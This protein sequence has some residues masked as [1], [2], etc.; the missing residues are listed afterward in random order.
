V[1]RL[2]CAAGLAGVAVLAGLALGA[3][4]ATPAA[5][6]DQPPT[7]TGN[8][9]TGTYSSST[10][11]PILYGGYRLPASLTPHVASALCSGGGIAM[12]GSG[13]DNSTEC[14]VP[15]LTSV[16]ITITFDQ[17]VAQAC[18]CTTFTVSGYW[19]Y[20]GNPA[21]Y[22]FGPNLIVRVPV[23][24]PS[25]T[26][27]PSPSPT[28]TPTPT[29]T[30]SPTPAA[31]ATPA[32]HGGS[33]MSWIWWVVIVVGILLALLGVLLWGP[34]SAGSMETAPTVP[35]EHPHTQEKTTP[36]TQERP[37]EPVVPVAPP[38]TKVKP[39]CDWAVYYDD[40]F[41]LECLREPTAHEC[42]RYII[43]ID[44]S[45]LGDFVT[46][47]RQGPDHVGDWSE[48]HG[49]RFR[50]P[51]LGASWDG[52]ESW[53]W[54]GAR[55]GPAGT[56]NWMQ[57]YG[58]L[59]HWPPGAQPALPPSGAAAESAADA[60]ADATNALTHVGG[61]LT[62]E[63]PDVTA[64]TAFL[65]S[66]L[67]RVRLESHCK[68]HTNTYAGQSETDVL[69]AATDECTYS[70]RGPCPVKLTAAGWV[71]ARVTGDLNYTAK[72][73]ARTFADQT[74]PEW[75]GE[76]PA[77]P[78]ALGEKEALPSMTGFL[79]DHDHRNPPRRVF[80]SQIRGKDARVVQQDKYR[81]R[82][83]DYAELYGAVN[84][85]VEV[86]PVSDRVSA[87]TWSHVRHALKVVGTDTVQCDGNCCGKNGTCKCA[88]EFELFLGPGKGLI[89]TDGH[90]YAVERPHGQKPDGLDEH[91]SL[92]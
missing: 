67:V 59:P 70:G 14:K 78:S 37:G 85:P 4:G 42:C 56:L 68:K 20:T 81:V 6:T 2:R 27:S 86:W 80:Q 49:E 16:T 38:P 61:E 21:D 39:A 31:P 48:E 79:P 13:P 47:G 52:L 82:L 72:R 34:W 55:S 50:I 9:L 18:G 46:K 29:P 10:G 65:E 58:E 66:T 30:P 53:S 57:G 62:R 28:P 77:V 76:G 7:V 54:A 8:T 74:G 45:L 84:V 32:T 71:A 73:I 17:P 51:D 88:P 63:P 44:T 40:G 25:P 41:G 91:W 19:N 43:R 75:L 23:A 5:A 24:S 90:E 11:Q 83:S 92:V 64:E 33:S 15:G 87:A 60:A 26:P 3:L 22:M 89:R 1:R 12:V 69:L 36:T 35:P